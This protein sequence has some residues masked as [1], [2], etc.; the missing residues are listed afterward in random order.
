MNKFIVIRTN[1]PATH[2]WPEC[3]IPDVAYL[4]NPHRHVFHV[5][6][7]FKTSKDREIE[8]IYMK[9][10]V[11]HHIQMGYT[12]QFLGAKSCETIAEELLKTFDADF[13]SVFEDNEN[14]AEIYKT[15]KDK[16]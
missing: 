11:D 6:M 5:E 7:K 16:S 10:R 15:K 1:F 12:N 14:G 4:R 2:C 9:Q 13:V 3:P 8:F